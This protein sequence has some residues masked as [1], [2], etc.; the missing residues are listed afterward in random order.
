MV[1]H[2]LVLLRAVRRAVDRQYNIQFSTV[3]T[4]NEFDWLALLN[5]ITIF[6]K[7]L[8]GLFPFFGCHPP[9]K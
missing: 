5:V 8:A 3:S 2:F 7:K 9:F 1:S 6:L 4:V